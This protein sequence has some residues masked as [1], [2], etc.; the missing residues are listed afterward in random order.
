[1]GE[2]MKYTT[3]RG[4]EIEIQSIPA[5]LIDKITS[6]HPD[7]EPPTYEVAT[8]GGA[9]EKHSLADVTDRKGLTPEEQSQLANWDLSRAQAELERNRGFMRVV[10][11]R[12]IKVQLPADD[13]W[14]AEQELIGV[15]VP[16]EPAA[17]R[18][19]YIET[20]V[21]G[22]L[23]DYQSITRLVV[24]ASGVSE[25]AIKQ[26][27][28]TFQN[29]VESNAA[30]QS[31]NQGGTLAVQREIRTGTRRNTKRSDANTV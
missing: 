10:M 20:E 17:R 23:E 31:S 13:S 26:A 29:P 30:G 4:V 24:E 14:I 25:A 11:L 28:D 15:Q 18:L 9:I 21:F 2:Q 3:S 6:A 16:T 12:G 27:S 1:M 19:H 8:M 22:G 7:P 5:M